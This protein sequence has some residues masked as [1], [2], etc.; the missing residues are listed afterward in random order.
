MKR[1]YILICGLMIAISLSGC[2]LPSP[3]DD[4]PKSEHLTSDDGVGDVPYGL[5]CLCYRD[6]QYM[7]DKTC[8]QAMEDY[9]KL[10]ASLAA[11]YERRCIADASR[12]K[13]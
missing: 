6:S 1:R 4:L 5:F 7:D 3:S 13:Q 11:S 10:T 8:K 9:T 12:V 2:S